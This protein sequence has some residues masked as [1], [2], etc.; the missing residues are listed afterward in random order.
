MIGPTLSVLANIYL[1]ARQPA[2]LD[3]E[4]MGYVTYDAVSRLVSVQA[5]SVTAGIINTLRLVTA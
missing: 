4:R 2:W 1:D 5:L 3:A